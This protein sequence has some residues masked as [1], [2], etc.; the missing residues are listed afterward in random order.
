MISAESRSE[1]KPFID[2]LKELSKHN[3]N[4]TVV[5]NKTEK[6]YAEALQEQIGK[7]Y[8]YPV[9]VVPRSKFISKFVDYK[10]NPVDLLDD[11][12]ATFLQRHHLK[13]LAPTLK[14]LFTYLSTPKQNES[15]N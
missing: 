4:I 3:T 2:T 14:E 13:T 1:T 12:K 8:T 9:F 11:G 7:L 10:L 6:Q 5:I 15:K